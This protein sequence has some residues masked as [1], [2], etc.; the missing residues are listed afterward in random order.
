MGEHCTRSHSKSSSEKS[1]SSVIFLIHFFFWEHHRTPTLLFVF[2]AITVFSLLQSLPRFI[3]MEKCDKRVLQLVERR[4]RMQMLPSAVHVGVLSKWIDQLP[5]VL[6][7]SH[8]WIVAETKRVVAFTPR[9]RK[10]FFLFCCCCC[11]SKQSS[12]NFTTKKKKK[13]KNELLVD[14]AIR[15]DS[16]TMN[17][18]L[19][20][21]TFHM[22]YHH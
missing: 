11:C 12:I 19:D 9:N 2:V 22:F 16:D 15:H 10:T 8:Y 18:L 13:K 17:S 1:K 6:V 7:A 14:D 4:K 20:A 21:S 5:S 3:F